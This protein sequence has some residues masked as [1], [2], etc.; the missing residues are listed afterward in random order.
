VLCKFN[1]PVRVLEKPK[2]DM[3][4]ENREYDG[5]D[6]EDWYKSVKMI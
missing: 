3:W 5:T 1:I 6:K 2:M 4:I